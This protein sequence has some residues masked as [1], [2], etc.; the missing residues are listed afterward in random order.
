[1][2]IIFSDQFHI[3][4]KL[5]NFEISPKVVTKTP[6]INTSIGLDNDLV[7]DRRQAIIWIIDDPV[8]WHKYVSPSLS[9][10]NYHDC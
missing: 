3:Y 8:S 6:V 9:V 2:A 4:W 1:M 10:L 5:L 7:P